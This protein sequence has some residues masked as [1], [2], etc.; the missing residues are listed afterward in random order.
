MGK[1]IVS[2]ALDRAQK[3]RD[4]A[5]REKAAA[6]DE[7]EHQYRLKQREQVDTLKAGLQNPNAENYGLKG[8]GVGINVPAQQAAPQGDTDFAPASYGLG[9]PAGGLGL[10]TPSPA[11]DVKTT[12]A[13]VGTG[14]RASAQLPA[15]GATFKPRKSRSEEQDVLAQIALVSNDINGFNSARNNQRTFDLDDINTGVAK[16]TPAELK[17]RAQKLNLPNTRIPMLYTGETKG[18][19]KFLTTDPAT[20]AVSKEFTLSDSQVRQMVVAQ[21]MA[22]KGF[23]TE[24][25]AALAG[26]DKDVADHITKWNQTLQAVATSNNDALGKQDTVRLKEKEL[27]QTA[28]YQQGS[29]QNQR[30]QIGASQRQNNK[31]DYALMEDANGNAVMVDKRALKTDANGVV[32]LPQGLRL[33]RKNQGMEVNADGSVIHNGQLYVPDPKVQGKFVPAKGIGPSAVDKALEAYLAKPTG[34]GPAT[35]GSFT[36]IPRQNI[37][38]RT[39]AGYGNPENFERRSSR[40]LFGG[41]SYE[42]YDPSTGKSLSTA[43]YNRLIG[44]K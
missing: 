19:Y 39:P 42:Y 4:L 38:A 3:E 21:E 33:P 10:R 9:T 12:P 17:E 22:D 7:S 37:T 1:G 31:P 29:L 23:G 43:E 20:G 13:E 34:I 32:A 5:M 41:V 6:R 40:G 16:M 35:N 2:D 36:P 18:G 44:G 27:D 28:A 14:L 25:M 24:A 8:S 26:V 30:A 15:T 11:P